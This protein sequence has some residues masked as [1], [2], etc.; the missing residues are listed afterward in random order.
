[1]KTVGSR[2]SEFAPTTRSL[3]GLYLCC[4]ASLAS[5]RICDAMLPSLEAHFA[6]APRYVANTIS[7]FALTYGAS[8]LF[9]GPLG[10]RVGKVKVAGI[11]AVVS[12]LSNLAAS[13]SGDIDQL[14]MARAASGAMTAGIVP[15]TM[16]WIGDNV[17][18][19][20]RQEA[21]ARL[22]GATI[23]GTLYGQW[24]GGLIS[25]LANWRIAFLTLAVAFGAGGMLTLSRVSMYADRVEP[26]QS[27]FV[28]NMA[29]VLRTPWSRVVLVIA[30]FE[31]ALAYGA[32][33][34]LPTHLH[35]TLGFSMSQAGLAVGLYG[36]GGLIYS[37]ASK[38]LLRRVAEA[39]C[40]LIGGGAFLCSFGL[41]S[42]Q[43]EPAISLLAC[44]GAG[45]GF[46]ALHN[47]LQLNATQMSA[48]CRGTAV[49]LFSSFLF[50]GQSIGV[51]AGATIVQ[52]CSTSD[53]LIACGVGLLAT[54]VIFSIHLLRRG[55]CH[56]G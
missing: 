7:V 54:A 52:Q 43:H 51:L 19:E 34:F 45:F 44:F 12:A 8:Q 50:F 26:A 35:N 15:M 24:A 46:Y 31:G 49:A 48:D 40:A 22:L 25:S 29:S 37:R 17:A 30:M 53:L 16:A 41:L 11:S 23:L 2:F 4:F 1:M 56:D 9:L 20:R 39:G 6:I 10:D 13:A 14:V 27:Q 28:R 36:I 42:F 47:T 18:Y 21:L 3:W 55:R 32:L 38:R 5:M 33:A